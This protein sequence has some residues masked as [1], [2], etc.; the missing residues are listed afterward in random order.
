MP[1]RQAGATITVVLLAERKRTP[2]EVSSCSRCVS[3]SRNPTSVGSPRKA[4]FGSTL[5]LG[6][7]SLPPR[8]RGDTLRSEPQ[9]PPKGSGDESPREWRPN[10]EQASPAGSPRLNDA[11]RRCSLDRP[12]LSGGKTSAPGH[13]R[14]RSASDDAPNDPVPLG[15][16]ARSPTPSVEAPPSGVAPMTGCA[17]APKSIGVLP[18]ANH[19]PT[20]ERTGN[21]MTRRCG[22]TLQWRRRTW[23]VE[24]ACARTC[25]FNPDV[26]K[27]H[28]RAQLTTSR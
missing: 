24:R 16:R 10:P 14:S 11:V 26:E 6:P 28:G 18:R 27:P 25:T 5:W 15:T 2:W 23:E 4:A 21:P 7:W 1:V 12:P 22:D 19:R 20:R 17:A 9:G 13:G 8:S 3:C